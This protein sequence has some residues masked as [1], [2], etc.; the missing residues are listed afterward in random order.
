V[1]FRGVGDGTIP[2][3]V[4]V[5]RL[6]RTRGQVSFVLAPR[7]YFSSV[8]SAMTLRIASADRP[9][10]FNRSGPKMGNGIFLCSCCTAFVLFDTALLAAPPLRQHIFNSGRKVW[11]CM[12]AFQNKVDDTVAQ[13]LISDSPHRPRILLNCPRWPHTWGRHLRRQRDSTAKVTLRGTRIYNS[14]LLC[15][16]CQFA[17][18]WRKPRR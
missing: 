2:Q 12:A 7:I 18:C 17:R 6:R 14:G 11:Q 10:F 5:V 3:R 13:A 9:A 16:F 15:A 1:G 4:S 8:A